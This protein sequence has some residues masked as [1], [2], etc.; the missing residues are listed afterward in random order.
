M[1][2]LRMS[3]VHLLHCRVQKSD[4]LAHSQANV[5]YETLTYIPLELV[6]Q[7]VQH[8]ISP[9][10]QYIGPL[11]FRDRGKRTEFAE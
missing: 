3:F 2:Y 7:Y 1:G 5:I 4:C 10:L 9:D 6:L 8:P 11:F